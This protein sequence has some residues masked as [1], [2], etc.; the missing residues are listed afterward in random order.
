MLST[1]V[2]PGSVRFHRAYA[3]RPAPGLILGCSTPVRYVGPAPRLFTRAYVL[4]NFLHRMPLNRR[5]GPAL[6]GI[7]AL[8]QPKTIDRRLP[9]PPRTR[10]TIF[11]PTSQVSISLEVFRKIAGKLEY[12]LANS[13]TLELNI[14]TEF[15][16]F[17]EVNT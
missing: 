12:S 1:R 10:V 3:S 8:L 4:R 7:A 2:G 15:G 17:T 11:L 9:W 14:Y 16:R 5:T 13:K 6:L